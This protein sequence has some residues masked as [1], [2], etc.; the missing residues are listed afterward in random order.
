MNQIHTLK[1]SVHKMI[2]ISGSITLFIV[3]LPLLSGCFHKHVWLNETCYSPKTC[4][5]CEK[6]IGEPADHDWEKATCST[7][8]RCKAC[9]KTEGKS[10]THD[11]VRESANTPLKCSYCGE[12]KALSLPKSGQV[13]IGNDL[14]RESKLSIKSSSSKSCYIKL[15]GTSG[16]DVFSFFVRAGDSVTVDVPRGYYY[17]YFSY[18]TTWYG[19]EYL[20]GEETT[21]SKD[22]ELR[23]FNNY[24]WSYRLTPM[25]GGNF[26]ET[27][28]DEEEFK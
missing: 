27:P 22:D 14:Y 25:I 1:N 10:G 5:I 24:I 3:C 26:S 15:K 20:F 13:Y 17:V 7:P 2:K 23:D 18:G 21:Y 19:A 16:I 8:K 6:T 11:W 9:G 12:L 4:K 28:V